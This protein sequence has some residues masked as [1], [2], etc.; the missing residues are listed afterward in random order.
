MLLSGRCSHSQL[1][2]YGSKAVRGDPSL[3]RTRSQQSGSEAK[4]I[5]DRKK[6]KKGR[7]RRRTTLGKC[8]CAVIGKP[9]LQ[10]GFELV[11]KRHPYVNKGSSISELSFRPSFASPLRFDIWRALWTSVPSCLH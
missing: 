4:M 6:Y 1:C 8:D 3:F 2:G 7:T 5:V 11:V 9:P 10:S